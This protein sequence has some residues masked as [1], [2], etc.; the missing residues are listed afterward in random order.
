MAFEAIRG[1]RRTQDAVRG[2]TSREQEILGSFAQGMSYA[3][4][5]GA[6]GIKT[7]TARSAIYGIQRKLGVETMQELALWCARNGMLGA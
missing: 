7:V 3:Q 1:G 6:R 4:I 5:A 2:L